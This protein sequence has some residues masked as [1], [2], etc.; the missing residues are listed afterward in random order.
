MD[1]RLRVTQAVA[2]SGVSLDFLKLTPSGLSFLVPEGQAE[3]VEKTLAPLEVKSSVR[4]DRSIVLVHAVNMR[5]EEGMIA[6]IVQTA[7]SNGARIDHIGD[8]HDR[9]LLAME[10]G[11]ATRIAKVLEE[12]MRGEPVAN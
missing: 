6:K 11:Q 8:M 5:D 7:I 10:S 4:R 12:S 3:Q 9:M 1:E 2:A